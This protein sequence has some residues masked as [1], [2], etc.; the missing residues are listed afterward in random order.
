MACTRATLQG[1]TEVLCYQRKIP[2]DVILKSISM[3]LGSVV[4]VV[5]ST[6]LISLVQPQVEF[7]PLFY[8]TVSAFATVGLSIG[9]TAQASS[10]TQLILIV[11][12][13]VGRVGVL[14]LMSALLG[15]TSPSIVHY[16]EEELLVG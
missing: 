8:E 13:Y 15:A 12:M 11:V 3:V 16:P 10:G 5:S 14:M 9:V 6:I 4:I 2:T 1:K 7:L